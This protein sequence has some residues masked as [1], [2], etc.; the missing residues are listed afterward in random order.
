MINT[1]PNKHLYLLV[2]EITPLGVGTAYDVL[3]S[4]CTLVHRFWSVLSS[5][6]LTNELRSIFKDATAIAL[7]FGNKEVFGPAEKPVTVNRILDTPELKALHMNL[8]EKLVQ[9]GVDYT[10]PE[11]V[12][13]GYKAHVTERSGVTF[14]EKYVHASKAAYLIEVGIPGKAQ[15]RFI[16]TK[17]VLNNST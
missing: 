1:M 15:A 16:K 4:H 14:K 13:D 17:F 11:W 5:D 7:K 10:A 8:Y 12:G 3:P 9:L 6:L 2:L